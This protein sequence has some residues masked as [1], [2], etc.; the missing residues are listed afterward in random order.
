[1]QL[2]ESHLHN[3]HPVGILST[4]WK[5]FE[6]PPTFDMIGGMGKAGKALKQVLEAHDISQYKLAVTLGIE[7][8]NV[9]RWVHEDRDPYA[10]TV[11]EIVR[12]L[13]QINPYAAKE[14]VDLYLVEELKD[15]KK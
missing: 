1:M 4:M 7:R 14:F 13:K 12:A 6:K 5:T 3:S 11:V 2:D 8:T 10:E 9:Y 15:E